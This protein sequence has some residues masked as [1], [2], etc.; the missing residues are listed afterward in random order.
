VW[1]ARVI[2]S[3]ERIW[4]FVGAALAVGGALVPWAELRTS[5][6][7]QVIS[8]LDYGGGV[9][10]ACAVLAALLY[11]AGR[12]LPAAV[13]AAIAAVWGA[14]A[15]YRL[16]ETLS[17]EAFKQAMLSALDGPA[18]MTWQVQMTVA[19]LAAVM[20][21]LVLLALSARGLEVRGPG[22]LRYGR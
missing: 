3:L 20:G 18:G 1:D 13:F 17:D 5:T 16:P 11:V 21:A 14:V 10:L 19:P 7:D 22:L 6:G 12:R 8:G 15:W 9:A 2:T 4:G